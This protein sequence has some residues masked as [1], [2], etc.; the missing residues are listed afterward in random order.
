MH[1]YAVALDAN[2]QPVNDLTADD[3]KITDSGK[4]ETIAIFRKPLTGPAAP[5]APLERTN[6]PGGTAPHTAVILFDLMN[7]NA[8]DRVE[9]WHTL[10]KSLPQLE[11]GDSLYFYLLN[12]EG[13]LVPIHP[14]GPASADDSSWPRDVAPVLDKA[15]KAASHGRPV[16]LGQEDQAKKT[17]H[18]LE[19][20]AT[21]LAVFPGRRDIIWITSGMQNAYNSKL[22]C[23]GDWVDCALYVPHLAVTLAQANVAVDPLSYS[24]DLSTAVGPMMTMDTKSNPGKDQLTSVQDRNGDTGMNNPQGA[25]GSDPAL[26]LTQMARLTGGHAYFRQDIR[27]TL[28]QLATN[29]AHTYEVAYAPSADN[30]DN[31]FHVIHVTC[32]R[33]GVKLQLRERYYALPDSRPVADRMKAVLVAA[34]QSPGDFSEIGLRTKFAPIG[35]GNKGVHLDISINA[36]DI[37]LRQEG[38]KYTGALYMLISDRGASGPLGDPSVSNLAPELTPAQ[39]DMVMKEGLPLSQDHPTSDAVQQVRVIIL[40]QNTNAVGSVTFPVK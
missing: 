10:A 7:Q 40:D 4:P 37:L 9:V 29:A 31:K 20:L 19:V 12:L 27:A 11:S 32:E 2:G 1:L 13:E 6:R 3:F 17:F 30:F 33:P 15:M 26:D 16:H 22:P 35:G 28:N 14:M 18:Q 21:Q 38:G 34:F 36:S 24:R 8:A 39:H 23:S 25:Q 5:L